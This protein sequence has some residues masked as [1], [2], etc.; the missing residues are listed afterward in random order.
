MKKELITLPSSI[1]KARKTE[2]IDI[3][4]PVAKVLKQIQ[5]HINGKH[6]AYKFLDWLFPTTRN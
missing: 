6:K 4:P 5:V 2:Y 1:T 3:T